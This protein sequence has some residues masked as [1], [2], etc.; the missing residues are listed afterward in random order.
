M[1]EAQL[2]YDPFFSDITVAAYRTQ[3]SAELKPL[4]DQLETQDQIGAAVTDPVG[5]ATLKAE[6]EA[7]TLLVKNLSTSSWVTS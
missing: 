1:D 3:K 2:A 6:V 4:Q 7:L 5:W